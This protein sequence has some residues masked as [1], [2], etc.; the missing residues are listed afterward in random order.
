MFRVARKLKMVKNVIREFSKHNYS[1]IEKK[2]AQAHEKLIQAQAVML[3]SPST[4]NA[5]IELSAQ[6]EWEELS[7]VEAAFF[8]QRSRINWLSLGDGNSTLFHRYAASR[9]ALNH[10]HFLFSEACER[11]DSQTG[12]QQLCVDYF[13]ELLDSP[14]SQPMFI[15][16]D[17]DLLFDF[18]C[19]EE[20]VAGCGKGFS[21]A[22][23]KE[24]FF[25]LPKNKTGGPDGYSAE[26][27][28][29]MWSVIGP[30]VTEAIME[31]FRSGRLLKQWNSANL[32]LIPKKQNTSLP[33]DFRPISCLNTVYKVISKL[34]ALRLKEILPL[35]ISKAQSAF[36]HGRLLAENV[37]LATDLVNGYNT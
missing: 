24:A 37:L 16:S 13:S 23:I 28:T 21:A 30:E 33:T 8:Y 20:Q 25:S 34:L 1:G 27:F 4:T 31:F 36:L 9:Q 12:I 14:I 11:I 18:K 35:M 5:S 17:L 22:D 6:K 19:S 26:F 7:S 15:Q 2:T 32:V 10:I 3:S 29:A